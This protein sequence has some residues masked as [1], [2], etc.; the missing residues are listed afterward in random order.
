[1]TYLENGYLDTII[2][3][4]PGMKDIQLRDLPSFIRTTDPNDIVLNFL[5]ISAKTT[6]KAPA[7]IFN[8]FDD[9]EQDVVNDLSS[10]FSEI[11]TIGPL[12]LL[13]SNIP[14]NGFKYITSCL[15]KEDHECLHWLDSKKPKSVVYVNFGSITVM[16]KQQMVEFA[17]GL[18]QSKQNF[19]WII[20]ADLVKGE[21][22]V[23][24]DQFVEEIKGRGLLASWCW[25]EKVLNHPSIG[26]F[27]THNGWN[28]T[29]ESVSGG[30]PMVCW[31]FFADQQ[32]NCWFAFSKWGIGMKMNEIVKRDKVEKLVRE[33]MEGENGKEMR[34]KAIEWKKKAEEAI[35]VKGSSYMNLN[36][37][38]E[39]LS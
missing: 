16:T 39:V 18:A 8:S 27:L 1:M 11:Y 4:I 20:R 15:W 7:V 23:L 21:S 36:K 32:T 26:G 2:D 19:L 13:L 12:L 14:E 35:T 38:V 24:P 33:L 28:S 10:M 30:V 31:P 9:I 29:L 25:Q 6:Y 22:A 17:W 3:W 34:S 5:I 37:L